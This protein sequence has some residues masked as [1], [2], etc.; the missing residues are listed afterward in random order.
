M[1]ANK[2]KTLKI[3]RHT[4]SSWKNH[5]LS[6][7]DRPLNK[8]GIKDAKKMS[9][10]L[11][12]KIKKVDEIHQQTQESLSD[13]NESSDD[14]YENLFIGAV[15]INDDLITF[16]DAWTVD[17]STNDT[18]INYKIDTGAQANILPYTEYIKLVK[19]P[20]LKKSNVMLSAYNNSNIPT[21]GSCIL[22]IQYG[23]KTVPILFIVADIY[24]PPIIGLKM[25]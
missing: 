6:D 13:S 10:E 21:K 4:K 3:I 23:N 22:H 5:S 16:D 2:L 18:I 11:S 12:K 7:F 17:L 15:F 24:S 9:F 25:S 14:S 8:R 20:K 19:R 1:I